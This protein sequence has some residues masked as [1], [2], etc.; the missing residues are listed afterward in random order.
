[1]T[2]GILLIVA[3]AIN[4]IAMLM[5]LADHALPPAGRVVVAIVWSFI[6]VVTVLGGLALV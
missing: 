4:E 2:L 3:A 5:S 1:M 6:V